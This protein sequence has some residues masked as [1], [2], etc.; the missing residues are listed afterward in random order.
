MPD[1]PLL[2][3]AIVVVALV[4]DYTN[5]AHD[6]ANAIATIVS[7]KVLSP[8]LAVTMAA[9]LNFFGALLGTE[10]AHTIG[11][12]IVNPSMIAGCQPL[13]LA[14]LAGAIGWN[15]LTWFLGLPSSSSHALIGGLIGASI[16]FGGWHT[17]RYTVI[18]EKVVLPLFLSPLLGFAG[19]FLLLRVL[20]R[21]LVRAH[22]RAANDRLRKLQVASSAFMAVSHGMNDAQ[23]TMGIISLALVIFHKLPTFS[24]PLWVRIAC[25]LAMTTG[26]LTGGWKIIKTMG[27]KIFKLEPIHG[28]AAETAAALVIVTASHFGA[29][30]STTHVISSSVIGA[31][32]SKRISAV[33]W[34]VAGR[35][36]LAW[37]L[38]LPGAALL[39]ALIFLLLKLGLGSG[40]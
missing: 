11:S 14:A 23:K 26:T 33:K 34:G 13:L 32:S 9:V 31:G 5:G 18:V 17:P 38:T 24:I 20:G 3:V 6:S 29:P 37:V 28:F 8:L 12:G 30:I 39:G 36:V 10:V 40:L 2:L 27:H 19:A 22:P 35:M 16:A 4:F 7:T 25:A 1:I 15:V 21:F